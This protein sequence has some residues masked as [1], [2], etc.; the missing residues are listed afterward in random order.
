[1]SHRFKIH[2][3][4]QEALACGRAVVALEST[5]IAYGMPYP[6]NVETA[7]E[8]EREVRA[9]GAAPA[10]VA[11]LDGEISVGL[12][13][14]DLD[15]LGRSQDVV[16]VSRRDLPVVVA[17][18]RTGATTVAA[19][20]IVAARAGIE[21]FVTGGIGGVHRGA[22]RSFDVSADLRELAR[23]RVAVVCAGTKA[24]LD[25]GLTLE[26]LETYGVPVLGFGTDRFPA[27]YTRDSGFGVD[28]RI[29]SEAELAEIL[30]AKRRLGLD[31]GVVVA[32]PIP[33]EH[34]MDPARVERAIREALA[35]ACEQ[36]VT[37]RDVTPFLLSR[38]EE[39]TA[40]DS[41]VANR[42]LIK[43]NARLGARLAG[44]L[45]RLR[46]QSSGSRPEMRRK[47][48]T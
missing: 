32:N 8:A 34:E 35:E 44:E 31:G 14:R 4:I 26:V 18:R 17:R 7:F 23:T 10:T 1:M 28:C 38:V 36:G 3:E 39:L 6:A 5:I 37:G 20:M 19:T 12:G 42:A 16:K 40:G 47:A 46:S 30:D 33:P 48:S 25:L 13:E 43:N 29:D 24:I 9:H 45:S 27:F 21:V 22:E 2:P 41:L 11:V 15:R